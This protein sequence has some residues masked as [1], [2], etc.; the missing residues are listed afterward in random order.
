MR[1]EERVVS[2]V[3]HRQDKDWGG[4]LTMEADGISEGDGTVRIWSCLEEVVSSR[5]PKRDARRRL[6]MEAE[7]RNSRQ[8]GRAVPVDGRDIQ[9]CLFVV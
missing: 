9:L 2:R 7:Q 4:E 6:D 3:P 5:R 8:I 1:R